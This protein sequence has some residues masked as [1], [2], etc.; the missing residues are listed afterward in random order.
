V[1]AR[2]E[3]G[4]PARHLRGRILAGRRGSPA[5][6]LAP[7]CALLVR[8]RF[9]ET[10]SAA[11]DSMPSAT[12]EDL[13]EAIVECVTAGAEPQ[14]GPGAAVHPEASQHLEHVLDHTA[15][16]GALVVAA[17]VNSVF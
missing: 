14:P 6:A 3:R 11:G 9:D 16:R 7:G 5:P 15:E 2:D 17:A 12:P 8:P 1:Y 13:A 10:T 4:V